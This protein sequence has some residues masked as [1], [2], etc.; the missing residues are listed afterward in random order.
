MKSEAPRDVGLVLAGGASKRMGSPKGLAF[1]GGEA[2]VVR[3]LRTQREVMRDCLISANEP[4]LFES[5]GAR[6]IAD[7]RPGSGPLAGIEAG[8]RWVKDV[9][10]RGVFCTPSD[11]PFLDARLI[12]TILD[13]AGEQQAVVPMSTGPLGHEPLFGWYSVDVL[14]LLDSVL[15]AGRFATHE[16]VASLSAVDH[17]PL[18]VVRTIG[19]PDL[20]FFNVNTPGDLEV[21]RRKE[22]ANRRSQG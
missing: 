12:R 20:L 19:D 6:V 4:E 5:L 1:V 8:L 9:G 3:V 17:V 11:A 22:D 21:A 14:P 13:R 7:S 2:I 18:S 16:F 10:A 15:N